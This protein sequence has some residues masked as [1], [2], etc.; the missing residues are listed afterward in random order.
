[1]SPSCFPQC[2][3][4]SSLEWFP[5]LSLT[6]SLSIS[7]FPYIWFPFRCWHQKE[8]SLKQIFHF[9][10]ILV[11]T[12]FKKIKSWGMWRNKPN[13]WPVNRKG[14][15]WSHP[16][17]HRGKVGPVWQGQEPRRRDRRPLVQTRWALVEVQ[18]VVWAA[19]P[20]STLILAKVPRRSGPKREQWSWFL[21]MISNWACSTL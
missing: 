10:S 4:G 8:Y 19:P 17:S 3:V 7:C 15:G 1:M 14:Y 13:S 16:D 9:L 12:F 2:L 11:S 18:L 6:S 20:L 21:S 5:L